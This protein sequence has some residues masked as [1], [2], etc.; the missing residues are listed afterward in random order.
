MEAAGTEG[1]KDHSLSNPFGLSIWHQSLPIWRLGA[2]DHTPDKSG[3]EVPY[4]CHKWESSDRG[5]ETGKSTQGTAPSHEG[6][7]YSQAREPPWAIF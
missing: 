2:R 6:G 4:F 5:W 7:C 1:L 3:E